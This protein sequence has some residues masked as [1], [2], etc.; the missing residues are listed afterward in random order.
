MV[1]LLRSA[2]YEGTIPCDQSLQDGRGEKSYRVVAIFATKSSSR[3]ENVVPVTGP[4]NSN[5]FEFL[6]QVPAGLVSQN[7]S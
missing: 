3:H 2:Q 4:T 1:G 6:G 7:V 5:W